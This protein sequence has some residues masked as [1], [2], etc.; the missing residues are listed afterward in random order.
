MK[1]PVFGRRAFLR[2]AGASMALPWLEAIAER[3]P[4]PAR[5]EPVR[6]AILVMPNGVLPSAWTPKATAD[7]GWEPSFA[8]QP[9]AAWQKQVSVLTGLAN[10]QSFDGDGH[11]AK[12]APLLTGR[13]I[14]HTGGRDLYNGISMDQL[15]A[16]ALGHRTLLPSLELG[17][18]PIY[19]V[20]DLGYSTVYGGTIAWSAADRPC[21]KE[22]VPAQVFDR[23]F[24]S[25]ALAND[26]TRSSVLDLV[27]D[28]AKR[29]AERLGRR[30]RDKLHEFQDSVRALELR[31]AAIAKGATAGEPTPNHD[32]SKAPPA[33]VPADYATHLGLMFDLITLAFT[34]DATRIV[35]FLM[36]NE[37][38]GRD[39]GFLEGCRGGFHEFSHH[40]NNADKQAAYQRINQWH[41][42]QF[43]TLLTRLAATKEGDRSLLDQSM[44]VLASAMSDGNQH[45]PH[46]LPIVLAGSAGGSLPQGRL[47]ASKP[48]TPLCRLWL[49]ML[50][51]F[52]VE[53]TQFADARKP[54]L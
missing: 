16:Q 30:D 47:I 26:P 24:R 46:D 8:L 10:R 17:C 18:D 22:I 6:M 7:G 25:K 13:K 19:P 4:A 49:S 3:L 15:A 39:F 48:D 29:L 27:Q 50:Q 12:V 54:L 23:L 20:D 32:P 45:S 1:L 2:G 35:T 42:E 53:A 51:R 37:V 36:A 43:A 21:T 33:G 11:Y 52:G 41:Y 40:E 44:V 34:M 28:D 31:I 38:S 9:L 5:H 14:R